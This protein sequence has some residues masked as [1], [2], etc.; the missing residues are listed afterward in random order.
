MQL[1]NNGVQIEE[2]GGETQAVLTSGLTVSNFPFSSH[3]PNH[4]HLILSFSPPGKGN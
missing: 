2:M 3:F 1:L 4:F